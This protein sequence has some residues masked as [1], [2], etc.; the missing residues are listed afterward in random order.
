MT[1]SPRLLRKTKTCPDRGSLCRCCRTRSASPSKLW[2]KSTGAVPSQMRTAGG[3]SAR[4]F[5]LQRRQHLPQGR[6][7]KPWCYPHDPAIGQHQFQSA[8]LWRGR[9]GHD[10]HRYDGGRVGG[11]L[12]EVAP[13]SVKGGFS[14]A[15]SGTEVPH[16]QPAR[17][18]LRDPSSPLPFRLLVRCST[19]G[20]DGALLPE[21]LHHGRQERDPPDRHEMRGDG[22]GD[23][24]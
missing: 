2:R 19:F 9:V 17:P 6:R 22:A 4:P 15:V 18:P 8:G 1:R 11:A 12:Q 5:P 10:L 20:H 21:G 14:Q 16:A 23:G 3:S 13:P 7:V 24:G